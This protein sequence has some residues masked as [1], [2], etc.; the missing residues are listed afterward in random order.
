MEKEKEIMIECPF[1]KNHSISTFKIIS[2]IHKC[3]DGRGKIDKLLKCK[4][5]STIMFFN[6][7][8]H[9]QEC[10]KCYKYF[11][12]KDTEN[13]KQFNS[14]SNINKNI[15]KKHNDTDSISII[16]ANF[17]ENID[18]I[19]SIA[20]KSDIGSFLISDISDIGNSKNLKNKE[21]SSFD[22]SNFSRKI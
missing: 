11:F 7:E 20:S 21:I 12:K 22:I 4:K 3:K 18:D 16:T 15:N 14:L 10:K 5:D 6:K 8:E 1:N 17:G 19:S 9:S 2:H 13:E